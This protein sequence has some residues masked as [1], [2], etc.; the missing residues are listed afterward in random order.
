MRNDLHGQ[1]LLVAE[2]IRLAL[3]DANGV[4]QSLDAAERDFVIGLAVRNDAI[5][6]NVNS[7]VQHSQRLI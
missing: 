6:A 5:R 1:V 2:A 3:D 7:G 4:V